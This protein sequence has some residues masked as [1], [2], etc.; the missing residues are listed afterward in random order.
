MRQSAQL[1]DFRFVQSLMPS[2]HR[3]PI[4]RRNMESIAGLAVASI[5]KSLAK[6]NKS[7]SRRRRHLRSVRPC[8]PCRAGRAE[9]SIRSALTCP[10]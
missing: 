1:A 7:Q 4:R 8:V 3:R 10:G 6:V 2:F 5:N 9:P